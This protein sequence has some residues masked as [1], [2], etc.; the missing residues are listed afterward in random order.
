MR[1]AHARAEQ[2][3]R[4]K[5]SLLA[6]LQHETR[7]PLNAIIGYSELLQAALAPASDP[8]AYIDTIVEAARG[9]NDTLRRVFTFAQLNAETITLDREIVR[10]VDLV[11]ER[12][13]AA[14]ARGGSRGRGAARRRRCRS[15]ARCPIRAR[16]R[17]RWASS[18]PT[19]CATRRPERRSL[20]RRACTRDGTCGS[21][22][23]TAAPRLDAETAARCREP[24]MQADGVLVRRTG[25]L[26]ARPPLGPPHR[27]DARRHLDADAAPGAAAWW[28]TL[29]LPA[30]HPHRPPAGRERPPNDAPYAPAQPRGGP[31]P[32][33][34]RGRRRRRRGRPR[35]GAAPRLDRR[36]GRRRRLV[37]RAHA[38]AGGRGIRPRIAAAPRDAHRQ[39]HAGAA[40]GDREGESPTPPRRR[41]ASR[42]P[43][44]TS[45]PPSMRASTRCASPS[46]RRSIASSPASSRTPSRKVAVAAT[47]RVS[48]SA[49]IC[50]IG[51]DTHAPKTIHLE[52]SARLDASGCA[53]Y[54]NSSHGQ[55]LRIDNDA[56][57]RAALICSS[58]GKLGRSA[59]F[60]PAPRTD[61]PPLGDPLAARAQPV[62]GLCTEHD[63]VIRSDRTLAPGVYCG[64][65]P[66]PRRRQG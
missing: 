30:L 42:P 38:P 54:S 41:A 65:H 45:T 15:R 44:S 33:A 56:T 18:P 5:E 10:A 47:A 49:P 53:V 8:R 22:C 31:P 60:E 13:A 37:R 64:R 12:S 11:E 1:A 21:K 36:G 62:V 39:H 51:L 58:G 43:I 28:P 50:A 29:A 66:R 2:A 24:F 63:L 46:R 55:G 48:G 7:T 14:P 61:C 19:P 40:P 25:G 17:R 6:L 4:L 34:R 32:P 3:D 52:K 27:R 57:I 59:S 16:S 26:G 35:A 23:R 9:L 20:S